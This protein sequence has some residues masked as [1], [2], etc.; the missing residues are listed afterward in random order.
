MN[1]KTLNIVFGI[2]ILVL[3]GAVGYFAIGKKSELVLTNEQPVNTQTTNQTKTKNTIS[4]V[5]AQVL[6]TTCKDESEG[7][8]IITSISKYSGP[9]GTELE[10]RGCNFNG[11]EGDRMVYI[12]NGQGLK[13]V[14]VNVRGEES[15]PK[16]LKFSL[17]TT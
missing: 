16:L 12:E 6:P 7:A 2:V 17:P 1:Q 3:I 10:I 11:F 8:P 9:L 5:S 14:L 13:S 4:P 15:T